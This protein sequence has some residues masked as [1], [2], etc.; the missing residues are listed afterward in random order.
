SRRQLRIGGL[1]VGEEIGQSMPLASMP[2]AGQTYREDVGSIIIVV[3]TDAP[4]LP[5]QLKRVARRATLGLGRTGSVSS[6]GSG[7]IFIAFST[8]N[9]NAAS[10]PE[11]A[12]VAML[13]NARIGAVF[14]A[15]VQA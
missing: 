4:L 3:A 11:T 13:S 7:D 8:A 12:Q 10:A 6:N 15:T 2:G 14:E 9:P 1:P 5:H